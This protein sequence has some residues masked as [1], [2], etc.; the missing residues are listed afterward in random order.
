MIICSLHKLEG[1]DLG[2]TNA[3]IQILQ[4]NPHTIPQEIS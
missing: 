1:Q 4:T 3:Y 2:S